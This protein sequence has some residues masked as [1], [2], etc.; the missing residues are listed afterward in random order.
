MSASAGPDIITDGLVLC[1]DA[2]NRDSYPGSGTVWR[3]LA[4]RGLNGTLTN[5]PTFNSGNGGSI[6][7]DGTNDYCVGGNTSFVNNFYS[8]A[9]WFKNTGVPSTNDGGGG[10]LFAQSNDF[11]HGV[12]MSNSWANQRLGFSG[13]IN[14]GLTTPDNSVPNNITHY[15]VGV[16]DGTT[17][18]IYLNGNLIAQRNF[19]T[20]PVLV[21][22]AFQIGRWGFTGFESNYVRYYNGIIYSVALYNRA[23]TQQEVLQN[24]NATKGR[25]F[26]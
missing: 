18:K 15:G 20:A 4:G 6:V 24:Y 16:Y 9:I 2:G 3:D 21:S 5:G 14:N 1:L 22:P 11:D 17:Q 12:V 7:F 23:L 19:S 25:F 26:L 13:N 8:L 10:F